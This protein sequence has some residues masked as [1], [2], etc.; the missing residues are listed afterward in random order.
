M[1]DQEILGSYLPMQVNYGST[2]LEVYLAIA[3]IYWICC[4]ALQ[5]VFAGIERAT[6]RGRAMATS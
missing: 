6:T 3:I 1:T 2:R 5:L 4:L